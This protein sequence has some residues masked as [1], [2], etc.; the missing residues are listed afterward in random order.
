VYSLSK[1]GSGFGKYLKEIS[2]HVEVVFHD[3]W[4][5]AGKSYAK[6]YNEKSIPTQI[7]LDAEGKEYYRHVC[8]FL[9]VE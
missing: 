6:Q 8:F 2:N 5:E 9:G 1:N 3:V 7:F 4:T